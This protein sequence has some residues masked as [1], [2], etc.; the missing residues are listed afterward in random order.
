LAHILIDQVI[1]VLRSQQNT[2]CGNRRKNLVSKRSDKENEGLAGMARTLQI[3][4]NHRSRSLVLFELPVPV[5]QAPLA[6]F[7][8]NATSV[9][10]AHQS[11]D[12]LN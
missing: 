9:K 2:N 4:F 10:I 6:G 7:Y 5:T 12:T 11:H 1:G 3:F 8:E